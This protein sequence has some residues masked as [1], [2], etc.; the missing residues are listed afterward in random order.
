MSEAYGEEMPEGFFDSDRRPIPGI[1]D[2]IA[3]TF[4]TLTDIN[5]INWYV[6]LLKEFNMGICLP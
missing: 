6:I 2:H 3:A 5:P 1:G 4:F